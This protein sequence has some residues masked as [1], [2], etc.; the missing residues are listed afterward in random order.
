MYAKHALLHPYNLPVLVLMMTVGA[1][2]GNLMGLLIAVLLELFVLCVISRTSFFRRH[3]RLVLAEAARAAA[4]RQRVAILTMMDE[5]HQRELER[6]EALVDETR[7]NLGFREDGGGWPA[8]PGRDADG[9]AHAEFGALAETPDDGE[10]LGLSRLMQGYV[11]LALA[12]RRNQEILRASD[13]AS[14]A[15]E[16][17]KLEFVQAGQD[18]RGR[19]LTER[20]LEIARRR[21]RQ[22]DRT[23][24]DLEAIE[25]QLAIIRELV[26][27]THEQSA[28][29]ASCEDTATEIDAFVQSLDGNEAMIRE[30][31]ALVPARFDHR[32]LTLGRERPRSEAGSMPE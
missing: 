4:A 2:S 14:L 31:A 13:R 18:P 24:D 23:K 9:C 3:I 11:R 10:G 19:A 1:I 32:V 12:Y 17:R 21:A 30:I 25:R 15:E 16:I 6:L 5:R 26:H 7:V 20:H 27:L 28:A 22:W 29:S 8:G